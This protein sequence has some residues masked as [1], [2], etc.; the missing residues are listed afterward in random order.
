MT[1]LYLFISLSILFFFGLGQTVHA[2]NQDSLKTLYHT[3]AN[4]SGKERISIGRDIVKWMD[5]EGLLLDSILLDRSLSEKEFEIRVLDWVTQY[6]FRFEFYA[7][8]IEAASELVRLSEIASDTSALTLGFYYMGF[9]NQRMGNMDMG[10]L[11]AQKCYDLCLTGKDEKMASSVLNNMGNIYM[12]NN[13]HKEAIVFFQKSLEIERKLDRKFHQAIRLGNMATCYVKLN[14]LNEALASALEGLEIDLLNARL[15]KLAIRYHQVGEVYAAMGNYKKAK[16]HELKALKYFE[17]IN[18]AYYQSIVLNALGKLET[19]QR[20]DYS[21]AQYLKQASELA[22][23]IHNNLLVQEA[24]DNLYHLYRGTNPALS[25]IYFEKSVALKDSVFHAENQRQINDFQIK[26]QTAEKQFEIE[27]QQTEIRKYRMRLFVFFGGI[28]AASLL[29]VLLI[30]IVIMRNRRNRELAEMNSIKD[31]FFSI[32]S[33]DLKNPVSIQHNA[34]QILADNADKW[35]ANTLS[36]YS[37][38]LLKTSGNLIDLLKNLLNW[39]LLHSKKKS[40]HPI[41]FNLTAALLPDICVI[42]NMAES[43]DIAFEI[44]MPQTAIITADQNM[45]TT[46]VRNLL[47]NAVKFTAAGGT[48]IFEIKAFGDKEIKGG[49]GYIVS[50]TDTG[51]GMTSEQIQNLFH[52]DRRQTYESTG[53]HGTG[54]GLIVCR[55]MLEEHGRKLYVESEKDKGSRFWFEI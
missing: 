9:A 4:A 21:A 47:S 24:S 22:E 14:M 48:V 46:I 54:L 32:I 28:I 26:Y 41:M 17:Q 19:K 10:L 37:G 23:S 31:K 34:L 50:I 53:E 45:L 13:Q 43:K 12:V 55:E 7:L 35:D 38:Q 49:G 15:D 44:Q 52:L 36:E 2:Q 39:S 8:T 25:L 6:L 11:Y 40:C 5:N 42:K 27:R 18:S 33:H 16:E 1:R 29:L 51:I 30:I 3:F 20:N